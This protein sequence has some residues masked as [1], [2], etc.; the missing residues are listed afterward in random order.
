MNLKTDWK[1]LSISLFLIALAFGSYSIYRVFS[2]PSGQVS[3]IEGGGFCQGTYK[4]YN[5]TVDN[6]LY[7]QNCAT[8]VNDCSLANDLGTLWGCVETNMANGGQITLSQGFFS[9]VTP[10]VIASNCNA[11]PAGKVCDA[12]ITVL[13]SAFSS[14]NN[15]SPSNGKLNGT[16]I[17]AKTSGMTVMEL[18]TN[19]PSVTCSILGCTGG[20][21]VRNVLVGY[22]TIN[23]NGF[24]N[25]I[26][27]NMATSEGSVHNNFE[28]VMFHAPGTGNTGC[29][30]NLINNGDEDGWVHNCIFE[31]GNAISFGGRAAIDLLW[32]VPQGNVNVVHSEFGGNINLEAWAQTIELVSST[33]NSVK[34]MGTGPSGSGELLVFAESYLGNNQGSGIVQLNGFTVSVVQFDSDFIDLSSTQ[35]LW[36]GSGT[37]TNWGVLGSTFKFESGALYSTGAPTI[38]KSNTAGSNHVSNDSTPAGFPFTPDGNGNF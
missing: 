27:M 29:A 30:T 28:Y 37:V 9:A 19:S 10:V 25:A 14:G 16:Q 15:Q 6:L 36:V 23:C 24:T 32:E 1:K 31:N 34:I 18:T 35:P 33:L 7:G 20:P 17:V 2:S 5:N 11:A 4:I 13:G 22:L 38:T 8:G 12:G 21:I 26:G 3:S